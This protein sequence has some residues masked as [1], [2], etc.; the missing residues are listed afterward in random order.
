MR[1][2]YLPNGSIFALYS[3]VQVFSSGR[4]CSAAGIRRWSLGPGR[5][6]LL[7]LLLK[8][9][10]GGFPVL[11]DLAVGDGKFLPDLKAL[12]VDDGFVVEGHE[13]QLALVVAV[14]DAHPHPFARQ[15]LSVALE[16]DFYEVALLVPGHMAPLPPYFR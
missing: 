5:S 12:R 14:M 2:L 9:Y 6:V 11:A 8:A 10:F 4:T 15:A 13:H 3:P 7:P 1:A 16:F